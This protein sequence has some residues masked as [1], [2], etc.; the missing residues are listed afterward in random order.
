MKINKS[1]FKDGINFLWIAILFF[2]LTVDAA[3]P[4]VTFV[5]KTI[6]YIIGSLMLVLGATTIFRSIFGKKREDLKQ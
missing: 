5:F 2:L 4:L 6:L 1:D 3:F